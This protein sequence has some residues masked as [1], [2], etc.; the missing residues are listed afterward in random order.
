MLK[1]RP[2]DSSCT[3]WTRAAL[4]SDQL[5]R[6]SH[7]AKAV[8]AAE[9]KPSPTRLDSIRRL[10]SM[11][12]LPRVRV[13]EQNRRQP[14]DSLATRLAK[15]TSGFLQ[16]GSSHTNHTSQASPTLINYSARACFAGCES[17]GD[18]HRRGFLIQS[19]GWGWRPA[20]MPRSYSLD[21]RERAVALVDD[22]RSRREVARLFKIGVSSVIRWCQR[23]RATGSPAAKPMGRRR[24]Q[25]VLLP[26]RDWLLAR[27][28]A[29][30]DLTLRGMQAELAARGIR[31]SCKAVWNFFRAEK[32]S[33]KKKPARQRAKPRRRGAQARALEAASGQD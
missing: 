5:G 6:S 9:Q 10:M 27:I 22:G 8:P 31:V 29:K 3:A 13:T 7:S 30:P 19:A 14:R 17:V 21:L 32:L 1:S 2:L 33:F 25:F 11:G 18:F 26:E 24:G 4:S 16:L 23:A 15:Q 12:S 28:T 20:R